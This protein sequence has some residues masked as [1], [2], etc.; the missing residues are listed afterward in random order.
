MRQL[1]LRVD[2][3][4]LWIAVAALLRGTP[5]ITRNRKRFE[6]V[7]GLEVVSYKIPLR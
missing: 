5:V 1:K 3:P 6:M 2:Y 4:D 7:P